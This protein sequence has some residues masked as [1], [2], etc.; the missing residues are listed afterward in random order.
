MI[1]LRELILKLEQPGKVKVQYFHPQ[2]R[3]MTPY[4]E[5]NYKNSKTYDLETMEYKT[6]KNYYVSRIYY[7]TDTFVIEA[8]K[9]GDRND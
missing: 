3:L 4:K 9:K 5:K 2:E 1:N 7:D 8:Y 6:D